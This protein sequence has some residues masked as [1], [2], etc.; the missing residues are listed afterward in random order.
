MTEVSG[1]PLDDPAPQE[2]P[3][4]VEQAIATLKSWRPRQP[5]D[6]QPQVGKGSMS[7]AVHVQHTHLLRTSTLDLWAQ[8]RSLLADQGLDPATTVLVNLFPDG[9]DRE[10]GQCIDEDGRVYCFDLV[11]DREQKA[12]SEAFL[13]NW[14]D[15]TDTWREDPLRREIADA[16]IW[17]PPARRTVLPG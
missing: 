8:L 5:R 3:E 9:G 12:V 17:R 10:F 4:R 7:Q 16:F 11:Y 6:V 13:H 15:I 14:T 1:H 2:R